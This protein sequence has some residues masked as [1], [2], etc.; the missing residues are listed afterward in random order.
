[1]TSFHNFSSLILFSCW[2]TG[3]ASLLWSIGQSLTRSAYNYSSICLPVL[4]CIHVYIEF[5]V[6]FVILLLLLLLCRAHVNTRSSL[7]DLTTKI[8]CLDD[9]DKHLLCILEEKSSSW[10]HNQKWRFISPFLL[11]ALVANSGTSSSY[12][13]QVGLWAQEPARDLVPKMNLTSGTRV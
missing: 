9:A 12:P 4:T 2:T 11:T 10:S 8:I 1:M 6:F 13:S 3:N 7:S 5:T